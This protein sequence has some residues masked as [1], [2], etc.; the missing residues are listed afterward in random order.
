MKRVILMLF[1]QNLLQDC[2][3]GVCIIAITLCSFIGL[4][5]LREQIM[6]QGTIAKLTKNVVFRQ[7]FDVNF[8]MY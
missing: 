4:I 8:L 2:L 7:D 5:W 6:Q 3:Q 1:R